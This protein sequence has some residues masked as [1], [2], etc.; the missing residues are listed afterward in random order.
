MTVD[1]MTTRR[2]IRG[3]APRKRWSKKKKAL[4]LGAGIP[5][6]M[7]ATTAAAA[8]VFAALAGVQGGG[9]TA[10]F[11]A[12]WV[13]PVQVDTTGVTF[14]PGND[15]KI[16]AGKLVLPTNLQFFAG[17]SVSI[18][19][20]VRTEVGKAGYI[21]G[22]KLDGLGAGYT[23]QLLT[24]C[25]A[26]ATNEAPTYVRIKITAPESLPAAGTWALASTAGVEVTPLSSASS[27][28]PTGV[29][30]APFTVPVG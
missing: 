21:S 20:S 27:A 25:G 11:N 16:Q 6:A 14:K 17:E 1:T 29:V 12:E 23:A 9:S 15:A 2:A 30:C 13:A 26:K 19:A 7:V 5:L 24:G 8:A 18:E 4:V 10:T 28:A 3:T 22:L